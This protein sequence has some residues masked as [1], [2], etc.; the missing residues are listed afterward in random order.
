MA[1]RVPKK[2][3]RRQFEPQYQVRP[4]IA[5]PPKKSAER[6]VLQ[7]PAR[8]PTVLPKKVS[9]ER[10]V[11][12]PTQRLTAIPAKQTAKP[13]LVS[14]SPIRRPIAI[15]EKGGG[16]SIKQTYSFRAPVMLP[17]KASQP[18]RAVTTQPVQ[19]EAVPQRREQSP[20][21]SMEVINVGRGL[22]NLISDNLIDDREASSLQN[23]QF[24]EGG[25][26]AKAY[27]YTAVGSGL[28]SAP[29]GLGFYNDTANDDRYLLTVDGTA[30]KYLD[31]STW[32][33]ISGATLSSSA[34]INFTQGLGNMYIWDATSGGCKLAAATLTRPTTTPKASF[35]IFYAGY[36]IASG[37]AGQL[38]R[39]YIS[40]ST[41]AADFTN[42]TG[43]LSD[44][45]GVPGATTFAGTGANYVDINKL[46]GDKITGLAKFQDA[47]IIFKEKAVFQM[48]FDSTGTPVVAAIS[49]NY[50]CVSH[51]SIDNVENDVFFLS[52]NG[53]YVLGNEPNFYNVIR[54]NE[55]SS[56][57]HPTIETLSPAYYANATAIFNQYVYYCG[58]TTS[59]T[60]NNKVLTYDRR[61]LAWSLLD[62][63][64][65]ECFTMFTDSSNVDHFYFTDA[66]AANV[67][68]ITNI[69]NA[70]GSAI[71]AQWTSKSFDLGDFNVYKRWV[72]CTILFRQLVGQVT[73]D[74]IT[75]NGT[76]SKSTTIT[77]SVSGGMGTETLG[78]E[79]LGGSAA[80]S[81]SVATAT[82]NI[83]YRV[84]LNVKS[85]T[86]KVK[87]SN[88]RN[89]ETFV[90]LGLA[91]RHRP[92]SPFSWPSSLKVT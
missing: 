21:Q 20:L 92:Y 62:H 8:R 70:N 6:K 22:N 81:S 67:Y 76:V 37:V 28:S 54:T 34:Q 27:G 57:I 56:R 29:R 14:N 18:K 90:I 52:R 11:L 80:S 53:V 77:S 61:F 59:G 45:T 50:G 25:A 16:R 72:D 86:I 19:S 38:N 83:P 73:L 47:L 78:E 4:K 9:A 10:K 36:H 5:I 79:L 60:T 35:S 31:G 65:P 63:Y 49:K 17:R 69:S 13:R 12:R 48:T 7:L 39:I 68:E 3:F 43:E 32:T 41:D 15:S 44:A 88:A 66:A 1:L 26:A 46:D 24:V 42:A 30:L 85:R 40:V 55:L 58:V 71:T 82:N 89:N 74:F 33:T 64:T 87:V 2:V 75:D 23:I 84:K 51:R 91:F